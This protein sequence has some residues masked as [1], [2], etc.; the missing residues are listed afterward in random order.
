MIG[1][2]SI[3]EITADESA[4]DQPCKYGNRVDGHAV[5]CHNNEWP[6]APRKCRRTWYTGGKERDEDCEGFAA[7]LS[8]AGAQVSPPALNTDKEGEQPTN[9][10]GES[11]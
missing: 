9:N 4:F 5:Y 11:A 8:P 2:F 10:K 6:D 3:V 7:N 1:T